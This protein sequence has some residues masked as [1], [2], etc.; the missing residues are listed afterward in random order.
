ME[1]A[2]P[3]SAPGRGHG[4]HVRKLLQ[5]FFGKPRETV[6]RQSHGD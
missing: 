4:P 3:E 5:H 2:A 1:Q 6:G